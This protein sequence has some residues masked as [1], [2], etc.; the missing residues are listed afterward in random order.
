MEEKDIFIYLTFVLSVCALSFD[1][2]DNV[3]W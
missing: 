3:P 2:G 1:Y